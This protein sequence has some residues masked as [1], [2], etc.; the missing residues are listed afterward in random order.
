[1]RDAVRCAVLSRSGPGPDEEALQC[2]N[3]AGVPVNADTCH[4]TDAGRHAVADA[5]SVRHSCSAQH[6][7]VRQSRTPNIRTRGCTV[8][9][10][11]DVIVCYSR[12]NSVI[13]WTRRR[14]K[15]EEA[16]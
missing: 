5:S 4:V 9:S 15:D 2:G 1:M 3:V 10:A 8:V 6:V 12:S 13:P 7:R 14:R 16:A 11:E